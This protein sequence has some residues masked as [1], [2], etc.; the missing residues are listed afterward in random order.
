MRVPFPPP[1]ILIKELMHVRRSKEGAFSSAVRQERN[2]CSNKH[3]NEFPDSPSQ[4]VSDEEEEPNTKLAK[5]V[6]R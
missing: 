3:F 4:K 5:R 1:Y 2:F 6:K